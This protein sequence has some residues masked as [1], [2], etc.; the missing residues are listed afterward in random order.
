[1]LQFARGDFERNK[2]VT[3]IVSEHYAF[4][5]EEIVIW[6]RILTILRH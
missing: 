3:D 6:V 1:M 2:D 4:I 5:W